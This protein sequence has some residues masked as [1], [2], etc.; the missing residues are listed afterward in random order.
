MENPYAPPAADPSA[1]DAAGRDAPARRRETKAGLKYLFIAALFYVAIAAIEM[2]PDSESGELFSNIRSVF[3]LCGFFIGLIGLS[4][5][6]RG[7]D[8]HMGLRVLMFLMMLNPRPGL[9]AITLCIAA[10]L[11]FL[12]RHRDGSDSPEPAIASDSRETDA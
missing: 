9:L 6:W 5:A 8:V 12:R 10:S 2:L 3:W 7:L 4:S 1:S 11:W